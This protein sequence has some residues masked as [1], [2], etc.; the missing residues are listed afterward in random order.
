MVIGFGVLW[1]CV[2]AV[3]FGTRYDEGKLRVCG[4]MEIVEAVNWGCEIA[5]C[6]GLIS[7]CSMFEGGSR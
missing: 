1:F 5:G 4:L 3:D 6:D 7:D 2:R